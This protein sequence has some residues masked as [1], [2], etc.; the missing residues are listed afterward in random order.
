MVHDH[1]LIGFQDLLAGDQGAQGVGRAATADADDVSLGEGK[2]EHAE[3]IEAGIHASYDCDGGLGFGA[4][5]AGE[6]AG[7]EGGGL[8]ELGSVGVVA[9]VGIFRVERHGDYAW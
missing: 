9:M 3:D 4:G 7:G 2:A 6:N 5:C 1:D 8:S